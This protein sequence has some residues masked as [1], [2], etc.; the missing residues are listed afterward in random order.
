MRDS[1]IAWPDRGGVLR[2]SVSVMLFSLH[3]RRFGRFG[4]GGRGGEAASHFPLP[5]TSGIRRCITVSQ[6]SW[7]G[8]GPMFV[9]IRMPQSRFGTN[10]ALQ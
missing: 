1:R 4:E 9:T 3:P 6:A 10:A 8:F 7:P 5:T 2:P